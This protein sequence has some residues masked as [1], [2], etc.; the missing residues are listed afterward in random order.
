MDKMPAVVRNK[1]KSTMNEQIGALAQKD[2]VTDDIEIELTDDENDNVMD[3]LDG[4]E[5][6]GAFDASSYE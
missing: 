3:R 4:H 6:V 5:L 1:F 2:G